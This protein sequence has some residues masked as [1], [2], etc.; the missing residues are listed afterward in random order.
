MHMAG[1]S[2]LV[3]TGVRG[4]ALKLHANNAACVQVCEYKQVYEQS[5]G[6]TIVRMMWRAIVHASI[7]ALK[8]A[9]DPR[10]GIP[11]VYSWKCEFWRMCVN[12]ACACLRKCESVRPSG[13]ERKHSFVKTHECVQLCMSW[14]KHSWRDAHVS[15]N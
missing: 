13:C 7:F 4:Q 6:L 9:Y 3:N 10:C 11:R 8:F 15:A 1:T 12:T 14:F 5:C 2:W